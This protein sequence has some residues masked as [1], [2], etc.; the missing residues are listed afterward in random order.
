MDVDSCNHGEE[1]IPLFGMDPH[2]M[3]V[4]VIED[5]VI[6]T[7]GAC[8]VIIDFPVFFRAPGYRSVQADI[9]IGFRINAVA[10]GGRG[11]GD[12][13][14]TL[15][16][17]PRGYRTA[18]FAGVPVRAVSPVDHAQACLAERSAIGINV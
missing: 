10:I 13:A 1:G 5:P 15:F 3:Q 6:H 18:P 9:P 11:T 7:L 17:P 8:A 12:F 14:G 2:I 16:F 4:I